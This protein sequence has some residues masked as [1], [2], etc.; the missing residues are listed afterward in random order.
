MIEMRHITRGF[1]DRIFILQ[2]LMF[3]NLTAYPVANVIA[4]YEK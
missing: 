3:V 2:W 1:D 4:E